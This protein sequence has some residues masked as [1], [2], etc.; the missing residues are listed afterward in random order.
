MCVA[1]T[2]TAPG[3]LAPVIANF[4]VVALGEIHLREH[5]IHEPRSL[6]FGEIEALGTK[7]LLDDLGGGVG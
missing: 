6:R 7:A 2:A 5:E 4:A 1:S 3:K